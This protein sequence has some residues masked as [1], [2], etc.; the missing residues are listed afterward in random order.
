MFVSQSAVCVH[1]SLKS[2]ANTS[3]VLSKSLRSPGSHHPAPPLGNSDPGDPKLVGTTKLVFVIFLGETAH[4][5]I[6]F[7]HLST[8]SPRRTCPLPKPHP[9]LPSVS[10][11]ITFP[12][13]NPRPRS[14]SQPPFTSHCSVS[15][16]CQRCVTPSDT[17]CL[18]Y[19]SSFEWLLCM[20]C[21]VPITSTFCDTFSILQECTSSANRR[22]LS[23]G[24]SL[25]V[26]LLTPLPPPLPHPLDETQTY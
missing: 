22:Y 10:L 19:R 26:H 8:W 12:S 16:P 7:T 21:P 15:A 20:D 14:P 5:H 6:T 25:F 18:P 4:S 1:S 11:P 24:P 17:V 3:P 9:I 23:G 13:P 2:I